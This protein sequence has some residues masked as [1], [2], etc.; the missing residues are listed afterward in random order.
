MV[1]MNLLEGQNLSYNLDFRGHILTFRAENTA[2]SRAFK[3]KKNAQTTSEQPPTN[4]QKVN[5]GFLNLKMVNM[6]LS[7]DQIWI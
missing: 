2:E 1:K 7:K 5:T 3:A 6:S 4:F